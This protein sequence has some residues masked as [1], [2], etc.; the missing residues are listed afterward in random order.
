VAQSQQ[1]QIV[2]KIHKKRPGG[3]AHGVGPEFKAQYLK[4]K[5][6]P[7]NKLSLKFLSWCF[8]NTKPL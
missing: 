1:G 3:V 6:I 4:K 2:L 5:E 7:P 8:T